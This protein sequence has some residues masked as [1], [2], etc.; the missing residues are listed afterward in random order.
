MV[1]VGNKKKWALRYKAAHEPMRILEH[2]GKVVKMNIGMF[3]E[4]F[5]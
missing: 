4:Y 2:P 5:K 1:I 3:S